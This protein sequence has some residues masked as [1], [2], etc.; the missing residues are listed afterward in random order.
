[1]A[2]TP[3]MGPLARIAAIASLVA[4]LGL[5]ASVWVQHRAVPPQAVAA[6]APRRHVELE[7]GGMICD[8]CVRKVSTQLRA[9]PGVVAV[10]VELAQQRAHVDCAADVPDSALTAAVRR[11]GHDYLGLV[12]TR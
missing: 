4:M 6:S 8:D 10:D 3:R 1:M 11:A 7:V 9:V 2:D 5:V 12:L